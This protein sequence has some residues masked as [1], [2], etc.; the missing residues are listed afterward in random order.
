MPITPPGL[1]LAMRLVAAGVPDGLAA[2]LAEACAVPPEK[3]TGEAAACVL[4]QAGALQVVEWLEAQLGQHTST[5]DAVVAMLGAGAVLF[6]AEESGRLVLKHVPAAAEAIEE[7]SRESEDAA[8]D[9]PLV[10]VEARA[11]PLML[12]AA[13]ERAAATDP[14]FNRELYMDES[15][16]LPGFLLVPRGDES[17]ELNGALVST[18][19]GFVFVLT[20]SLLSG[21]TAGLVPRGELEQGSL[22]FRLDQLIGAVFFAPEVLE[23]LD[24]WEN[25]D[26]G[27]SPDGEL[28]A[29]FEVRNHALI[30]VCV[31]YSQLPASKQDLLLRR[32]ETLV[33]RVD[34]ALRG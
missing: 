32:F 5:R 9:D 2:V 19:G 10:S 13:L 25:V 17:V 22:S 14:K 24:G 15:V 4:D 29:H 23:G 11:E 12:R 1:A 7:M 31:A 27:P 26:F 18:P 34:T 16:V 8:A 6:G 3:R 33:G 21:A 20:D 28:H 30:S